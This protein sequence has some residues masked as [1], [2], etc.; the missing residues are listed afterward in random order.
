MK[1][2]LRL[3]F[4]K[5]VFNTLPSQIIGNLNVAGFCIFNNSEGVCAS[6]VLFS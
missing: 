6:L 3:R 2:Y 4:F 5:A 1:S